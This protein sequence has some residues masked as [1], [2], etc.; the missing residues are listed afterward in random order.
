MH[1]GLFSSSCVFH[2]QPNALHT[3]NILNMLTF[4]HAE[5]IF[6]SFVFPSTPQLSL[7]SK[8]LKRK[9]NRKKGHT[10]IFYLLHQWSL[11]HALLSKS[12]VF[13]TTTH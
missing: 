5:S 8:A 3:L 12:A 13:P 9:A 1:Q 7:P 2:T 11:C 6:C 4:H 10:L